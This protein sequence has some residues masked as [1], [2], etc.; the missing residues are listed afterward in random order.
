M[1]R[2]TRDPDVPA[3]RDL[4]QIA[5]ETNILPSAREELLH[6]LRNPA[7]GAETLTRGAFLLAACVLEGSIDAA[8]SAEIRTIL[9]EVSVPAVVVEERVR[10]AREAANGGGFIDARYQPAIEAQPEIEIKAPKTVQRIID[11]EMKLRKT[12]GGGIIG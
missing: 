2:P 1:P 7:Q 10:R 12:D 8:Q 11:Q 5:G 4:V 3:G 6:L 9:G